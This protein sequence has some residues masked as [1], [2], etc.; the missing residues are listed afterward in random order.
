MLRLNSEWH[1]EPGGMSALAEEEEINNE[2]DWHDVFERRMRASGWSLKHEVPANQDDRRA[3]FIGYHSDLNGSYDAGEW[4][5]FELKYSERGWPRTLEAV[6]QIEVKYADKTWGSS[7]KDVDLWVIAPYVAISHGSV[8]S[9]DYV[10]R[11]TP[12]LRHSDRMSISRGQEIQSARLLNRLG[13]GYLFSWHTA[14]FISFNARPDLAD[15]Y[16]AFEE[17]WVHGR[18]VPAFEGWLDPFKVSGRES[19]CPTAAAEAAVKRQDGVFTYDRQRAYEEAEA[20][21]PLRGD[22]GE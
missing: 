12:H 3:D 11:E 10:G 19:M 1:V 20:A 21:D 18:G 13:Y 9:T 4:V 7:G 14:P 2:D 22:C 15:A 5:G 8:D 17:G 6:E 16:P